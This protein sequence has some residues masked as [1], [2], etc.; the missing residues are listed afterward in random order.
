MLLMDLSLRLFCVNSFI[1]HAQIVLQS[2]N[3][4]I[5]MYVCGCIYILKSTNTCASRKC[6]KR[7]FNTR[8]NLD[9]IKTCHYSAVYDLKLCVYAREIGK[10]WLKEKTV[11]ACVC[12]PAVTTT[13]CIVHHQKTNLKINKVYFFLVC[14]TF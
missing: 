1:V 13:F 3:S 8:S 2:F 14:Y 9:P 6:T 11:T 12:K 5:C 4:N 7:K 10:F